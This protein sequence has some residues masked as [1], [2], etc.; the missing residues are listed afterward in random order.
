MAHMEKNK[1]TGE[2]YLRDDWY[3]EDVMKVR[4]DLNVDQAIEVLCA[5]EDGF[6]ANNG[7][8]WEVIEYT[9]D[10]LYPALEEE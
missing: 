5:L 10:S 9:A 6:D 3:A 8:N 7:I 2:W 1:V 4:P